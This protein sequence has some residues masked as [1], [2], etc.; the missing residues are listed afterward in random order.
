M[1][2][3]KRIL[4]RN[5]QAGQSG[6]SLITTSFMLMVVSLFLV[7]GLAMYKTWNGF[8]LTNETAD[9]IEQIQ[10]ALRQY[11]VENGHYPCPASLT[12]AV[13][14]PTFGVTSADV[15]T[16]P[17]VAAGTF[18]TA[19][20]DGRT[21]R[22]GAV[23]VRT[24]GLEDSMITDPYNKRYI[25]AVTEV[26]AD[27]GSI[28][29]GDLG[30]IEI[31]D[32][33]NNNAT[34]AVGN[35]VHTLYSMGSDD[36]GAYAYNGTL[37]QACQTNVAGGGALLSGENCDFSNNAVFRNTL[38]KSSSQN[39]SFTQKVSYATAMTPPC[40]NTGTSPYKDVAF[41][42]DTSGSMA[43][44]PGQQYCP[45]GM[46]GCSRMDL[47]RWAL[48]RVLPTRIYNNKETV[49]AGKTLFTGFVGYG[50]TN[51]V[52][53]KLG[54]PTFDD[55]TG[56][57]YTP[58]SETAVNSSLEGKLQNMCPSGSTP[59]GIHMEALATR[60]GDGTSTQPNK[61]I[62]LSDGLSNNGAPP[63]TVA[64]N[65][66]KKY[67]NLQVDIIDLVGNNSMKEVAEETGGRYFRTNNPAE[68]IQ[69]FEAALKLCK[70]TTPATPPVDKRGCGSGGSWGQ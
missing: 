39:N 12:A 61:I 67:P 20:R 35:I 63:L 64:K 29:N 47:A 69:Q 46:E 60:M 42:L 1:K 68:L 28:I 6:V 23:P 21:V 53:S 58:P 10:R 14:T 49:D 36:N 3:F 7:G 22:A 43:E 2:F 37:I 44:D 57:G 41:L 34:A 19:G 54:D 70:T 9:N 50:S 11:V 15:C 56:T 62:V 33:N 31:R 52:L 4:D 18:R 65:L 26:F 32:G 27:T 40:V 51:T 66:K 59:L 17:G 45:V 48:R 16:A 38:S 30:A 25:Y 13:D 8:R 24:L 55:P 5:K